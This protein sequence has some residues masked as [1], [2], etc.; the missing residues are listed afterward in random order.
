MMFIPNYNASKEFII[1][2]AADLNEQL[3]LPGEE[4]CTTIS[5]KFAMNGVLLLGSK[6]STNLNIEKELGSKNVTFFGNDYHKSMELKKL[7]NSE[8]KKLISPDCIQTI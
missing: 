1:V 2:P 6:G 4:A 8:R 7:K 5:V 3:S